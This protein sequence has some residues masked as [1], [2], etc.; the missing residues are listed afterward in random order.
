MVG[1]MNVP[2]ADVVLGVRSVLLEVGFNVAMMG[3][4]GL[5]RN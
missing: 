4:R 1:L 5:D 2:L 3:V